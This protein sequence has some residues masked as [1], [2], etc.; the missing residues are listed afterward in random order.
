MILE[1]RSA[2]APANSVAA[3]IVLRHWKMIA[4]CAVLAGLCGLAYCLLAPKWYRAQVIVAPVSQEA[5]TMLGSLKGQ[6]GG[7]AALAGI[8]LG[9]GEE[10]KREATARL[11]SR[12]FTYAFL[13]DEGLMPILFSDEWDET[14]KRWKSGDV[15]RQPSNERA[16]K[17]FNEVIC[18]VS[19]DRRNGLIKVSMD[20]TDPALAQRWANRLITKI[21]A[22]IR[23]K[24][25]AEAQRNLEYLNRE[26]AK[27]NSI[28]LRLV[29]NHLI[30]TETRNAMLANVREQYAFRV[31]D[32]AFQPGPENVVRPKVAVVL[33]ASLGVGALLGFLIA[34]RRLP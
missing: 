23:A 3:A 22:D 24:A 20:W 30:E 21:N 15:M 11:T 32:P 26:L 10:A 29:L 18:S 1:D 33:V 19:E 28:D 25:G 12:E 2:D 4:I 34:A 14:E 27:T 16:F 7:L 8:G 5:D 17:Y 31:I 6:L 9:D 13:K